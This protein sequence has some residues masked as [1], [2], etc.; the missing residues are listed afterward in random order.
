MDHQSDETYSFSQGGQKF[1]A[2]LNGGIHK[3]DKH[4]EM[5][6][7]FR[8]DRKLPINREAALK[9][10]LGLKRRLQKEKEFGEGYK[11]FLQ[12][13][14]DKGQAEIIPPEEIEGPEGLVWYLPH[15]GVYKKGSSNIRVVFDASA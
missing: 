12:N 11:S 1:L 14:L 8:E 3:N 5:P 13:L 9:H 6:L 4:Y 7:P 10:L 2:I 15:H